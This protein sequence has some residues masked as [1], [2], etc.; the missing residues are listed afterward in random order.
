MSAVDVVAVIG[1]CGPERRRHAALV[2][3]ELGR[4]LLPASLLSGSPDPVEEAAVLASWMDEDAGAVIEVPDEIPATELIGTFA[5][6]SDR[7]RLSGVVCVVDAVHILADLRRDD[8]IPL[9]DA[10]SG[11]AAPLAPRALLS[12]AQIEYASAIVLVNWSGLPKTELTTLMA[13]LSHLSPRA[14]LR[15][16]STESTYP[17]DVHAYTSEQ[18]RAGWLAV[19]N[20]ELDPVMTDPRVSA[21]RYEQVR[22]FH[23]GRLKR[24]LDLRVEVGEFGTLVRSAGFCRL[25]TRPQVV[26]QWDHVGRVISV[27]PRAY[28]AGLSAEEELLAVGQDI[29]L[30]GL[31]LDRAGLVAALDEAVLT[32]RELAAGAEA[33]ARFADPFPA[34]PSAYGRSR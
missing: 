1:T 22:P 25:A 21:F 32:D 6:R 5:E 4:Q 19:L 16:R 2:A 20:G 24:A 17:G 10:G 9:R 28:D 30:I 13:L 8:D 3:H 18:D 34:W 27:T 11:L 33:W 23:P 7:T 12:V 31:D 14:R 26:A 15:L 29:A